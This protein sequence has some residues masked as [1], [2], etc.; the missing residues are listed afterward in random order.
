MRR[1]VQLA[2]ASLVSLL[3]CS[4]LPANAQETPELATLPAVAPGPMPPGVS[5]FCTTGPTTGASS[6]TCPVVRYNGLTIW[7]LRYNDNRVSMLIAAIDPSGKIIKQWE[8]AGARYNWKIDIDETKDTV[9]FQGQSGS[10]TMTFDELDIFKPPPGA[11]IVVDVGAPAINCFYT[12]TDPCTVSGNDSVGDIPVP[13]GIITGPAR[14]QT[15]TILGSAGSPAAGKTGYL[16]R[17]DMT[18]A[19]SNEEVPCV[20][21]VSVDFGPVVQFPYSGSG[22]SPAD[23]FV[24]TQ[25]GLGS[26]GLFQAVKTGSVIDFVFNEP[27]CA[28]PTPGTGKTSYFF[29]VTSDSAPKAIIAKVGWPGLDALNTPARGPAY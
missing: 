21:D 26:I 19:V 7:A 17:V 8:K 6:P 16:Y 3:A 9:T 23:V 27:V 28:G 5:V 10:V 29:G 20:T 1:Y 12:T 2:L 25:G 18:Q 15:R 24:I 11:L 22:S 4:N 14:L 13:P